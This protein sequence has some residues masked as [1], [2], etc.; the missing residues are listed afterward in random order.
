M[1]TVDVRVPTVDVPTTDFRVDEHVRPTRTLGEQTPTVLPAIS[2]APVS[3][4][5]ANVKTCQ[6]TESSRTAKL[7]RAEARCDARGLRVFA[8][9]TLVGSGVAYMQQSSP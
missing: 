6:V 8:R 9:I 7:M 4:P 2:Y 5:R 1:R 3:R